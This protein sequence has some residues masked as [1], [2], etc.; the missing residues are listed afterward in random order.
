MRGYLQPYWFKSSVPSSF[1]SLL[2][3]QYGDDDAIQSIN[4]ASKC[5]QYEARDRS[6][7]KFVI[8]AVTPLQKLE[9]RPL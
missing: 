5:L 2:E 3:G 7:I 9:I 8:S 4:L 6:D 1:L